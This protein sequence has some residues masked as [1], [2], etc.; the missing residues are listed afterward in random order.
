VAIALQ[1]FV[2]G[3]ADYIPKLNGNN[4]TVKAAIDAIQAFIA[5]QAGSS[6]T[7][8]AAYAALWGGSTARISA[9]SLAA[10]ISTTNVV[11]T[12]GY[13]YVASSGAVVYSAG[14]SVDLSAASDGTVYIVIDSSGALSYST[15]AT[16]ALWSVSKSGSTLSTLTAVAPVATVSGV[17]MAAALNSSTLGA[18]TSLDARLEAIETRTQPYDLA[19]FYPGVPGNSQLL[20]RVVTARPV[21]F[22][23]SL[24]G[25]YAKARVAA[26]GSTTLTVKN[27]GSSIGTIVFSAAGTTGAFTFAA[28]VTTAAGDVLTIEGPATADATLA[29][30]SITLVGTRAS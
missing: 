18:F 27:N 23:T 10:S 26:T 8:N 16:D 24:T 30:I 19:T 29:D 14:A 2:V 4:S 21:T 6:T 1:D 12:A 28:P 22:P 3:D 13:A 9:S 17:D 7:V 15:S 20:V 25:S 5:S 11:V